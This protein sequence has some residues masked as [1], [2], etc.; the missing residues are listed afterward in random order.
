MGR[1]VKVCQLAVLLLQHLVTYALFNAGKRF[2]YFALKIGLQ[3]EN[4]LLFTIRAGT[5]VIAVDYGAR[6]PRFEP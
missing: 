2:N 1:C 6:G 4:L 5:V 3:F